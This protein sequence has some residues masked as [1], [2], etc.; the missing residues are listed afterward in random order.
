MEARL[1][2]DDR[3]QGGQIRVGDLFEENGVSVP[4]DERGKQQFARVRPVQPSKRNQ[5]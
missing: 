2:R 4:V 5:Q 1:V 3:M